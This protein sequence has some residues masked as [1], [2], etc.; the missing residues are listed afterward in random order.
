MEEDKELSEFREYI[1]D[2]KTITFE[3]YQVLEENKF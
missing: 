1:T 3:I 2:L